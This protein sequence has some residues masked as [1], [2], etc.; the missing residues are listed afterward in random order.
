MGSHQISVDDAAYHI[1]QLVK[2]YSIKGKLSHSD[3]IKTLSPTS[4]R[5]FRFK[6]LQ[7]LVKTISNEYPEMRTTLDV[8]FDLLEFS[9]REDS[10][11]PKYLQKLEAQLK[12][13]QGE[14]FDYQEQETD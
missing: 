7:Y 12:K 10:I 3:I 8:M 1:M 2:S 13:I 5:G 14:N 4:Y 6:R 9:I 11:D